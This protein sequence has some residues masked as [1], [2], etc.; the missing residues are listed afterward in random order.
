MQQQPVSEEVSP[1]TGA[2]APAPSTRSEDQRIEA[3]GRA[4][5]ALRR[6]IEADLGERDA[7][8]IRRIGKLSSRLE[9]AGRVLLQL[10]FEPVSFTLGTAALWVHKSLELMEIGHLALHGAFDTLPDNGRFRSDTFKWKAPIDEK[11]WRREHNLLHHQF[12]NIEGK[13]PDLNFAVFRLSARVP[14]VRAHTLQPVSNLLSWLAFGTALGMHASGMLD[15]YLRDGP[16]EVLPDKRPET[17]RAARRAFVSKFV[18]HYGKEYVLFPL[19]A[20]PFFPKVLLGNLISEVGRD[21]FAAAIIYCGHVGAV[22][23]PRGTEPKSRAHWYAMQAEGA[24]DVEIPKALSVLCGALDRQI[25]HHLFPRLP[26]NRLREIA[27]R[28]RAL[29]EQHGVRYRSEGWPTT[30][31]NVLG[32][33]RRIAS[34]EAK[35]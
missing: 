12:T 21:V 18:R 13:D 25:E 7:D 32:E 16:P 10:S 2:R 3:F 9:I 24:R 31:R 15:L 33:L 27:P 19:L 4:L 8:Y 5:D 14:F 6:E 28:V 17:V 35:A 29:C 1:A 30:L 20:G 23:Y 11:S 22:D 26:P 34:A